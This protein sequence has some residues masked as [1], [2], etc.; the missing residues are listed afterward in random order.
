M[1]ARTSHVQ[2][3]R[4]TNDSNKPRTDEAEIRPP[5]NLGDDRITNIAE[6]SLTKTSSLG[7]T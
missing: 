4:V 1:A 3:H 7:T 2:E 5:N 6:A